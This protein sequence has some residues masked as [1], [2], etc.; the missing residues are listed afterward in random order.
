MRTRYA[1][2]KY[3]KISIV[4]TK[5]STGVWQNAD[6]EHGKLEFCINDNAPEGNDGEFVVSLVAFDK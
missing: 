3:S 5:N 6:D 4:K 2:G 1:D